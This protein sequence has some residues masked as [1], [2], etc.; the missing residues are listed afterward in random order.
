MLLK[1]QCAQWDSSLEYSCSVKVSVHSSMHLASLRG[2]HQGGLITLDI[3]TRFFICVL[4][5]VCGCSLILCMYAM[6]IEQQ[7]PT[8]LEH[9]NS[10]FQWHPITRGHQQFGSV[11]I[12]DVSPSPVPA[13]CT[14]R[15]PLKLNLKLRWKLEVQGTGNHTFNHK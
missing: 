7:Y 1:S 11:V 10:S 4:F 2:L 5:C 13:P 3:A 14:R 12:G 8:N 15:T 6:Q 9:A